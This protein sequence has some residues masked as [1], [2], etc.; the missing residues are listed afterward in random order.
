MTGMRHREWP[1]PIHPSRPISPKDMISSTTN[2]AQSS[3][4][5]GL[6]TLL[7]KV[8]YSRAVFDGRPVNF[9]RAAVNTPFNRAKNTPEQN[10]MRA[11]EGQRLARL[12]QEVG[13][14]PGR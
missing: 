11:T 5:A 8:P 9:E 13:P 4:A 6:G 3:L 14:P 12:L 1:G 10:Q 7:T 2:P